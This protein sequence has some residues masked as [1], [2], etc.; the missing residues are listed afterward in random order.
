MECQK[1]Y[2]S[3]VGKLVP[4]IQVSQLRWPFYAEHSVARKEFLKA[5]KR[6]E[7]WQIK[8][9]SQGKCLGFVSFSGRAPG[10]L[11][12]VTNAL[13]LDNQ[14][15]IGWKKSLQYLEKIARQQFCSE[16]GLDLSGDAVSQEL[17]IEQGYLQTDALFKKT[18]VY[19]T[20]LVLGGGGAHGSYQIGVWQALKELNISFELVTGTSVGAL[21]GAFVL[22]DDFEVAKEMWQTLSTEAVMSFPA[23][24]NSNQTMRE[25]ILQI[26]SL[27]TTAI[28]KG[29]VSTQPLRQLLE[30]NI[31]LRKIE[32]SPIQLF[33]V[34]TEMSALKETVVDI[35]QS[36]PAQLVD[37]LLA[38]ASFFPAMKAIEIEGLSYMDGGY[39]NNLPID[40]AIQKGATDCIAVDVKGP[41]LIKRVHIPDETNSILLHSPWELGT[42]LVFD[43]LRSTQNL[44]LG[45]LETMKQF[46]RF[47]GYWYTFESS[48]DTEVI[49][50][51][52]LIKMQKNLY[53]G[54]QIIDNE[55]LE[56]NSLPKLRKLYKGP[57]TVETLG[58]VFMELVAKGFQLLPT[59]VYTINQLTKELKQSSQQAEATELGTLSVQ[60]WLDRFREENYFYSEKNQLLYLK[61]LVLDS[62]EEAEAVKQQEIQKLIQ[63]NPIQVF[64]VLFIDYL[65]EGNT[66]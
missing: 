61:K 29:G 49:W 25:L 46:G 23:A 34:T 31:S 36:N 6:G 40:V 4:K 2:P 30:K 42:F 37:W 22:Q 33:T 43:A 14:I 32:D 60:E 20:A 21:N 48:E 24:A 3:E 15:Q 64:M 53:F 7:A 63:K 9:G 65:M 51:D 35:K 39:R 44:Q 18:L 66:W 11:M 45:Y 47:K 28:R 19:K 26:A 27:T 38:S 57:V 8:T 56:K 16:I 54:E 58:L 62:K 52:F 5:V 1:I 59:K 41:G 55:W 13:F 17:L 50:R 10:K 12:T